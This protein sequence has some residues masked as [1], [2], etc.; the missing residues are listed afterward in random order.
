LSD[1]LHVVADLACDRNEAMVGGDHEL[2]EPVIRE[3]RHGAGYL[4][5]RGIESVEPNVELAGF[6]LFVNFLGTD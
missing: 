1:S 3:P 2:V 4:T 6:A 5:N